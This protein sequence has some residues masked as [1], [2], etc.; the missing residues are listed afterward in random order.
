VFS[1]LKVGGSVVHCDEESKPTLLEAADLELQND[2]RKVRTPPPFGDFAG[3]AGQGSVHT[4]DGMRLQVQKQVNLNSIVSHFFWL[5]SQA[6]GQ[7]IYQ[8]SLILVDDQDKMLKVSTDG[9][10]NL[11]TDGKLVLGCEGRLVGN[12]NAVISDQQ[13]KKLDLETTYSGDNWIGQ[14]L[15]GRPDNSIGC[16]YVQSITPNLSLGGL[17]KYSPESNYIAKE[18]CGSYDDGENM[19]V[20][21]K[22]GEQMKL[23]Y[24]RTVNPNRV[25]LTTDV[26]F[27][28]EMNSLMGLSAQYMLKQSTLNFGVDSNLLIKSMLNA[29]IQPGI[30]MQMCGEV[31]HA[32]G[33]YR[34]GY[35]L[36]MGS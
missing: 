36:T 16:T 30:S 5:G 18:F 6:V 28:K 33:Q 7:P 15:F 25:M 34:F 1:F 26:T 22:S 24:R 10:F 31:Q 23:S 27:D 11:E 3:I 4:F 14:V 2:I 9:D 8:Y 19:V 17:C 35:G 12:F 21:T 32:S 29:E 20:G 13:G